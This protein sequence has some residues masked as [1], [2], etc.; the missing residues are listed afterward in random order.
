MGMMFNQ[1]RSPDVACSGDKFALLITDPRNVNTSDIDENSDF[2]DEAVVQLA[3]LGDLKAVFTDAGRTLAC[4]EDAAHRHLCYKAMDKVD[5]ADRT[6]EMHLTARVLSLKP[7]PKRPAGA[8]DAPAALAPAAVATTTAPRPGAPAPASAKGSPGAG[9]GTAAAKG[10]VGIRKSAR[11][12]ALTAPP[13][14]T[15][16]ASASAAT[17]TRGGKKKA[18][19]SVS[20]KAPAK[21]PQPPKQRPASRAPPL[22]AKKGRVLA[23]RAPP[24][25]AE[26]GTAHVSDSDTV[27]EEEP[28]V[29]APSA[30]PG[31]SRPQRH[32]NPPVEETRQNDGQGD[33]ARQLA[34]MTRYHTQLLRDLPDLIRSTMDAHSAP[35]ADSHVPQPQSNKR[36]QSEQP[37][38]TVP[39]SSPNQR[40]ESGLDQALCSPRTELFRSRADAEERYHS[41]VQ[42]APLPVARPPPRALFPAREP[43]TYVVPSSAMHWLGTSQAIGGR[44]STPRVR[45]P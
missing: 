19:L 39:R 30:V 33:L 22:A 38:A 9:A 43:P 45:C 5:R 37:D 18:A 16:P 23:S 26:L 20:K 32:V 3:K 21:K 28:Q 27:F 42:V 8:A 36:S 4:V 13:A 41:R 12:R 29:L 25:A 31:G 24:P 34:E 15:A 10:D 2:I 17:T 11:A 7:R 1:R 44:T 35:Q 40:T 14:A 6:S